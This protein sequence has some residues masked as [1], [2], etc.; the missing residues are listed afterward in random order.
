MTR[1]RTPVAP[2]AAPTRSRS[3]A[4]PTGTPV[5]VDA[6]EVDE[7]GNIVDLAFDGMSALVTESAGAFGGA[8]IQ[9]AS[10][11]NYYTTYIDT[12]IFMLDLATLG[13]IPENAGTMLIGWES[14]GKTLVAS[15]IVAGAQRKYPG[16]AVLYVDA[17]NTYDTAWAEK[18]GVDLERLFIA[19]PPRAEM[20]ID[21]IDAAAK[22]GELSM[23]IIDS[24]PA[25][26]PD[27]MA[28]NSAYDA[29]M[30][31]RAQLVGLLCTKLTGI[32]G[33]YNGRGDKLTV[34]FINQWRSMIGG[35]TK[36][37]MKVMPCGHQPRYFASTIIE[38][39]NEE[40]IAQAHDGSMTLA[41][42]NTHSFK[43][44]K[45]KIGNSIREAEF[46]LVRDPTDPRGAGYIDD[47]ASVI[48]YAKRFDLWSG[49][50]AKQRLEGIDKSFRTLEEGANWLGAQP[51]S[52][53][54]AI[55]R[56]IISRARSHNGLPGIPP[57]NYLC[58]VR[59]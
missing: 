36:G 17:E 24:L 50:G 41:T 53:Q 29:T 23:I 57:D 37:P 56:E 46:V 6:P 20:V 34:V 18:Q 2:V 32:M 44:R 10:R 26:V 1:Q 51:L 59:A 43:L 7:E 27:V 38:T 13:G 25:L 49:G 39:F 55:R 45:N 47:A 33:D 42:Q 52:V 35:A 3:A 30:A 5:P 48:T 21:I 54:N 19:R 16:K 40:K 8:F 11:S 9:R 12:G 4:T 28:T 14:S 15:R 58:G 31:K 22:T